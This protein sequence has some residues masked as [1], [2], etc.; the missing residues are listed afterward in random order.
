MRKVFESRV[1]GSQSFR[2][3]LA[4]RNLAAHFWSGV[5]FLWILLQVE[6]ARRGSRRGLA[7][8]PR[9]RDWLILYSSSLW[10]LSSLAVTLLGG[11]R[12]ITSCPRHPFLGNYNRA[13]RIFGN[14]GRVW[15]T[16]L[17][18]GP[19]HCSL[20]LSFSLFLSLS[21]NVLN[22]IADSFYTSVVV[23]CYAPP[24]YKTKA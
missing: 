5:S 17:S 16:A 12:F 8:V 18:P 4:S 20:S 10:G 1:S 9:A 19:S 13:W 6:A 3:Q 14:A 23:T 22:K 24:L 21:S 2:E 7:F 15:A 11:A